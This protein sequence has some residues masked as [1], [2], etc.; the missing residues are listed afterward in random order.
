MIVASGLTKS[1]ALARAAKERN[2]STRAL[3]VHKGDGKYSVWTG[4]IKGKK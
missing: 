3:A 2:K 1:E 4:P